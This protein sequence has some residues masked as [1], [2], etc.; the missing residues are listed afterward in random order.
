MMIVFTRRINTIPNGSYSTQI[1]NDYFTRQQ[2]ISDEKQGTV[3]DLILA[4]WLLEKIKY[5]SRKGRKR[6]YT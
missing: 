4:W 1:G 3:E 5:K 2:D 6:I